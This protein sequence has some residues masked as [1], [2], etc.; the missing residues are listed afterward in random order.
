MIWQPIETA[1]KDG[2][3]MLLYSPVD[4]V[5]SSHFEG[6]V[7]QGF[8]WRSPISRDFQAA[9]PTHWMPLPEPPKP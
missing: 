2:T 4:G 3:E 1:P 9:K 6:G 8:P 5:K 7:W